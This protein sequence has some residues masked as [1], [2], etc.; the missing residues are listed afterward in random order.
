MSK[1]TQS[2]KKQLTANYTVS[3]VSDSAYRKNI[4]I[5][6]D[7]G[8]LCLSNEKEKKENRGLGYTNRC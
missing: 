8:S 1:K 4:S 3:S 7:G 6:A 5:P 2:K